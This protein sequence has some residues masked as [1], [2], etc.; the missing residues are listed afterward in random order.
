[1]CALPLAT[2]AVSGTRLLLVSVLLLEFPLSS[3]VLPSIF[4]HSF[5]QVMQCVGL[6]RLLKFLCS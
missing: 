4:V 6:V 3:F 2:V 5:D 1:M